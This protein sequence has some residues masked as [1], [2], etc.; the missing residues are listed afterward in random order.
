MIMP[1][2]VETKAK[3]VHASLGPTPEYVKILDWEGKSMTFILVD[4]I[5]PPETPFF[6]GPEKNIPSES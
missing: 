5:R 6:V 1:E 4:E 2:I 3:V